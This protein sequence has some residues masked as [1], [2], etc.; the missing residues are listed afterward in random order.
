MLTFD[1]N[2]FVS[3]FFCCVVVRLIVRNSG[4]RGLRPFSDILCLLFYVSAYELTSPQTHT[5]HTQKRPLTLTHVHI[6]FHTRTCSY[7]H[8]RARVLALAKL[9]TFPR[10]LCSV[11]C[12]SLARYTFTFSIYFI[13]RTFTT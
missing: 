5:Q 9:R 3:F 12:R 4:C 10:R 1:R 13:Y 7:L 6:R 11:W 2:N 8:A